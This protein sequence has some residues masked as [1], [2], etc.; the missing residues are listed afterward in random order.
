MNFTK[1]QR[2]PVR[3]RESRVL[4]VEDVMEMLGIGQTKAYQIIRDLND[5]IEAAGYFRPLGGRV[6]ETYFRE[7]FYLGD[8]NA[9]RKNT[10]KPA[11]N[12]RKE[13]AR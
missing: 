1:P 2:P 9:I 4:Y 8:A 7:R 5:E 10:A 13:R 12:P 11:N 6:S 3:K